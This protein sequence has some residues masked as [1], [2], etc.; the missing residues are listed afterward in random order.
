M[1][2]LHSY[3]SLS[4]IHSKWQVPFF[5]SW[6]SALGEMGFLLSPESTSKTGDMNQ[7]GHF[8]QPVIQIQFPQFAQPGV[9]EAA[10][11]CLGEIANRG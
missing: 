9:S 5:N 1:V 6:T 11:R 8:F 3:V 2:I 4:E 7:T 10:S